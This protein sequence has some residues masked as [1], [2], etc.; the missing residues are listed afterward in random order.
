MEQFWHAFIPLFVAFDPMG[1][2]P[3]FWGLTSRLT[4]KERQRAGRQAVATAFLVVLGFLLVSRWLLVL[5]G[6]EFSDIMIA[7]G[8]ILIVLCLRDLLLPEEAPPGQFQSPGIVP[9]GVPLLA[10]PAALTTVLLVKNQSGWLMT[11]GALSASL[12]VVWI[13]LAASEWLRARLGRDG[14][15]IVSR[16]ASLLLTAFGVMLIRRGVL[17]IIGSL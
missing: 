12:L 14:A 10:G 17:G 6:L 9:V 15:Q 4:A 13:T 1:L 7:G 5:M 16:I 2:L 11:L 8:A 3:L